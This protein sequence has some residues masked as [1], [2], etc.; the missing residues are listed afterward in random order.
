M[1]TMIEP[2]EQS[3]DLWKRHKEQQHERLVKMGRA[4]IKEAKRRGVTIQ[5][6]KATGW[7]PPVHEC[8]ECHSFII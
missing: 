4:L 3:K 7:H 5:E 6:L 2:V 8:P 1:S